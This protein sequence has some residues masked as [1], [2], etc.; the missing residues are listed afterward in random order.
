MF[1]LD[2]L[3]YLEMLDKACISYIPFFQIIGRK[4]RLQIL[5][6]WGQCYAI[7][8][9]L[10]YIKLILNLVHRTPVSNFTF[11]VLDYRKE[12]LPEYRAVTTVVVITLLAI[13]LKYSANCVPF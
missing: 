6:N 13:L 5:I 9:Y 8:L 4:P 2:Y 12:E 7:L 10:L 3:I 11:N 1:W